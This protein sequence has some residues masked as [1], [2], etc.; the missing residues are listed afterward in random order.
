[1]INVAAAVGG[2]QTVPR[3]IVRLRDE[4]DGKLTDAN[5]C[6]HLALTVR[7]KQRGLFPPRCPR[8]DA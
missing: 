2:C 6:E 5:A 3:R 1:M 4:G 8:H 7:G